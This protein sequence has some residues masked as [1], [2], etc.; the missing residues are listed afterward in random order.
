MTGILTVL[1]RE[2]DP[3]E[4]TR[5]HSRGPAQAV[6]LV[7]PRGFPM[8][9]QSQRA[10][11]W[12]VDQIDPSQTVILGAQETWAW[13]LKWQRWQIRHEDGQPERRER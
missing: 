7:R 6:V 12:M 11:T 2:V 1:T 10:A 3:V 9:V 13:Y 5:R 4:E 8:Q